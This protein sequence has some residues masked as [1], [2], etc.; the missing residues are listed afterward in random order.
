MDIKVTREYDG[1]LLRQY[2]K[3]P[4]GLSSKMIKHLKFLPDG[5]T[6]NGQHVTVRRVLR[7]QDILSLAIEDADSAPIAPVELPLSIVYEDGDVV[8]PSKP[9]Q[10][11]THPSHGHYEDTVANA[12]AFRYQHVDKF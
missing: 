8:V 1:V 11:P 12:L 6:V 3:K 2:L 7:E 4:L 5:I 10:M 9:A